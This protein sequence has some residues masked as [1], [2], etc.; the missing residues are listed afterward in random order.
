MA[1]VLSI[2]GFQHE[3]VEEMKEVRR[4]AGEMEVG[5]VCCHSQLPQYFEKKKKMVESQFLLFS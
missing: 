1:V 5:S 4:L 3:L 2:C